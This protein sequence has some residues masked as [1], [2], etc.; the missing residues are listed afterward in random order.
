MRAEPADLIGRSSLI[1]QVRQEISFAA[2]CDAKVLVTGE[3]GTGKELVAHLIHAASNRSARPF[4]CINCAG[5]PET[6]LESELFGHERGSFTGAIRDKVGL[7]QI[8][9]QGTALLDEVGEMSPR[10]QGVLLRFLESGEVQRVGSARVPGRSNVRIIAATNRDLQQQIEAGTFRLDVYYRLN[11]IQIHVPPLRERPEDVPLLLEHFLSTYSAHH[12]QSRRVL[13]GPAIAALTAYPWPG[14]VRQ[15]KNVVERMALRGPRPIEA[16]H[17]PPE[18][19][20]QRT[21]ETR[22]ANANNRTADELYAR[23]MAGESFWSVVYEPFMARDLTRQDVR[24]VVRLGLRATQGRYT[25]L[26]QLF[27]M[28]PDDSK[29]LLSLLRTHGCH[30]PFQEFHTIEPAIRQRREHPDAAA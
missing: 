19:I 8:A 13:T 5:V 20:G 17:L 2:Q 11:V 1:N 4:V 6:L 12:Q 25:L 27:N 23:M 16:S 7:L 26:L 14:N 24:D 30:L 3:S 9:D 28:A 10:M 29:P 21:T 22:R 18:I 15:L